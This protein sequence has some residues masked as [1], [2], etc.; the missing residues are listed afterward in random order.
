MKARH[1]TSPAKTDSSS[2]ENPA[3]A[4]VMSKVT[5]ALA[6]GE[7]PFGD[8]D[9]DGDQVIEPQDQPKTEVT[10]AAAVKEQPKAAENEED[11]DEADPASL[12]PAEKTAAPATPETD[13]ATASEAPTPAKTEAAAPAAASAAPAPPQPVALQFK[14]KPA[15]ELKAEQDALFEKKSK[16]FAEYSAGTM[17]AED[18]S[19]IDAEVM[20]GMLRIGSEITLAQAQERSAIF[21]QEAAIERVKQLAKT[22]GV[23]DYDAD[24]SAVDQFNAAVAMVQR[25]PKAA[26]MSH[27]EFYGKAH[28]LVLAARGLATAPAAAPAA[29]TPPPARKDAA[30]PITLR[31]L[32][33]AAVP[34]T[35]GG[36]TEQLARLNGLDFEEALAA[37]PKAQRDAWMDS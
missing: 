32:P 36:L 5:A 10:A 33:A 17:T 4:D 9:T 1:E 25:D 23:L 13:A 27:D 2:F 8:N 15:N 35:G 28:A 34:N 31:N 29:P 11:G 16:A 22:S 6:A 26:T 14:T 3:D 7:D 30:G 37:L 20:Q 12:E 18:Y 21:T 19:K 24:N